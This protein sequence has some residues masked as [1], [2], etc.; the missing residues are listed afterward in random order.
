MTAVKHWNNEKEPLSANPDIKKIKRSNS[1]STINISI[2]NEDWFAVPV[3]FIET[4]D[5]K[6]KKPKTEEF[7]LM[8]HT[9]AKKMA[10]YKPEFQ[11][12]IK[13]S[14]GAWTQVRQDL[15]R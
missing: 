10:W 14:D 11:S 4:I 7:L 5:S 12:N 8:G 13:Q 9:S 1:Y 6:V 2:S 15:L 3:N